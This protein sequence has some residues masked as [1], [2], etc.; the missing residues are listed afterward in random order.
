MDELIRIFDWFVDNGFL[1]IGAMFAITLLWVLRVY[2]RQYQQK[3][4]RPD[5]FERVATKQGF[6]FLG[7]P[8]EF[9]DLLKTHLQ[10]SAF[11]NVHESTVGGYWDHLDKQT[12]GTSS[13]NRVS[14]SNVSH[15]RLQRGDCFLFDFCCTT[16]IYTRDASEGFQGEQSF[17]DFQTVMFYHDDDAEFPRTVIRPKS[18]SQRLL[19]AFGKESIELGNE[20][21]FSSTYFLAGQNADAVKEFLNYS[22]V[23][24]ILD[25]AD[26]HVETWGQN[27]LVTVDLLVNKSFRMTNDFVDGRIGIQDV[28]GLEEFASHALDLVKT[29][30]ARGS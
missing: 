24:K 6:E 15:L 12:R 3:M 14:C 27:V 10:E 22:I 17:Q 25:R 2:W 21:D 5:N 26:F 19:K 4:N 8:A 29:I 30:E 7:A 9:I 1:L 23:S 20:T 16:D 13:R 28:S 18:L 11:V